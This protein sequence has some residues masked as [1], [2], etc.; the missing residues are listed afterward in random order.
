MDGGY[1]ANGK[2]P[3]LCYKASFVGKDDQQ[4]FRLDVLQRYNIKLTP[5]QENGLRYAEGRLVI[6]TINVAR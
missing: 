1:V 3:Q 4:A 5:E 6:T 2:M